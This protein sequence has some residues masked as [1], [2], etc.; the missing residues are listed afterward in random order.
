MNFENKLIIDI[1]ESRIHKVSADYLFKIP[2]KEREAVEY[3]CTDMGF[4]SK[5]LLPSFFK[6]NTIR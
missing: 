1:I 6:C 5:P 4:I 3:I 2:E